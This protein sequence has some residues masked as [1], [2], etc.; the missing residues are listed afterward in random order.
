M[1]SSI[2]RA[3]TFYI[4]FKNTGNEDIYYS[5]AVRGLALFGWRDWEVKGW[6]KLKVAEF[7]EVFQGEDKQV[8][9]AFRKRGGYAVYTMP[10]GRG[11][12]LDGWHVAPKKN[13]RYSFRTK[14]S[15]TSSWWAMSR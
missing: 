3:D 1:N 4:T 13:F 11:G 15:R 6:Y 2:S 8:L 5:V 10:G 14:S 7:H 12:W 9:F